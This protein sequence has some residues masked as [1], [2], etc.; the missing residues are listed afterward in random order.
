MLD[1]DAAIKHCLEVAEDNE[2]AI[3]WQGTTETMKKRCF[4]CAAEHR[5]VAEWL[6]ELK[7]ARE[8]LKDT[9]DF[10]A[11][12]ETEKDCFIRVPCGECPMYNDKNNLCR[13]KYADAVKRLIE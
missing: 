12:V 7:E 10:F 5:E 13:W 9:A 4:E 3:N 6:T 11:R 2:A 1:I 8:I